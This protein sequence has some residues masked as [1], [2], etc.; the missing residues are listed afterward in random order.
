LFVWG[1]SD[2]VVPI[3][4]ARHVRSALPQ[5]SHLELE[6][7]H[8]PQLERPRETHQATVQFLSPA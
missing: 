7:G 8:V 2:P 3:G 4:F 5:A 1:R 6:C